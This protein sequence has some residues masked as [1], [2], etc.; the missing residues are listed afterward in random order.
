MLSVFILAVGFIALGW[1]LIDRTDD[2]HLPPA[3]DKIITFGGKGLVLFS[4]NGSTGALALLDGP[5]EY[6]RVVAVPGAPVAYQAR[7]EGD[8][9]GRAAPPARPLFFRSGESAFM[10]KLMD[11]FHSVA[12]KFE[13]LAADGPVDF[14]LYAG[15]LILLLV[16]LRFIMDISSWHFA[17]LLLGGLFFGGILYFETFIDS[18]QVQNLISTAIKRIIPT[19]YISPVVFCLTAILLISIAALFHIVSKRRQKKWR[20]Y[21]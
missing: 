1:L 7:D 12:L 19:S 4:D 18:V 21:A 3:N 9:A 14:M 15:A 20:D 13:A 5:G 2:I 8:A 10:S 11:K 16:S 17:N 6:P